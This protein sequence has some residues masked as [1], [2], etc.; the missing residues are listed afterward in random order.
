MGSLTSDSVL[1][2]VRTALPLSIEMA[3]K[4]GAVRIAVVEQ[5]TKLVAGPDVTEA[6]NGAVSVGAMVGLFFSVVILSISL[7]SLFLFWRANRNTRRMQNGSG[8]T[9]GRSSRDGH[10]LNSTV[11]ASTAS[12][13]SV[14]SE[15]E[16]RRHANR[17]FIEFGPS[18]DLDRDRVIQDLE[19]E[20]S[21]LPD[22][23][24]QEPVYT[25]YPDSLYRQDNGENGQII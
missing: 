10:S 14:M 3:A 6:S 20:S 21:C 2:A 16:Q 18:F 7:Y 13:P 9:K 4:Y 25:D 23:V 17:L 12:G 5:M 22:Y 15:D 8:G 19:E 24:Y 11:R 1:E